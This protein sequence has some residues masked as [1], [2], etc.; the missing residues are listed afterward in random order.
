LA[1]TAIELP[2]FSEE[3]TRNYL[4]AVAAV[5]RD[6]GERSIADT[7]SELSLEQSRKIHR[8]SGGLPILLALLADYISIAGFRRL[9]QV[10]QNEMDPDQA[11]PLL[12]QQLIERLIETSQIRDTLLM[13]GRAP[14]GLNAELLANLLEISQVEAQRRLERIQRLSFVKTRNNLFFLHDEMYAFL[15]RQVYSDP[16]DAPE[17][18]R[19]NTVL[20]NWYD[21]QIKQYRQQLDKRFTPVEQSNRSDST[22]PRLDFNQIARIQQN[23]NQ[24]LV[25]QL[26]Y[27]LRRN[28]LEGSY[29]F[30]RLIFLSIFGANPLLSTHAQAEV[31][32]FFH[33]REHTNQLSNF[34]DDDIELIKGIIQRRRLFE[35]YA[36]QKYEEVVNEAEQLLQQNVRREIDQAMTKVWKILALA[37]SGQGNIETLIAEVEPC[38]KRLAASSKE[39]SDLQSWLARLG[40]ALLY[41]AKG[42]ASNAATRRIE[43]YQ[44]AVKF[45]RRVDIPIGLAWTL[46]NLGFAHISSG[47]LQDGL[48]LIQETIEIRQKIGERAQIGIG[49]ATLSLAHLH[50]GNPK[51][52]RELADRGLRLCRAVNYKLGEGLALRNIAEIQ[53][54]STIREESPEKRLGELQE[55]LSYAREATSIFEEMNNQP[56]LIEALI[57][58]G[59]TLRDMASILRSQSESSESV[60][61]WEELLQESKRVLS[62]AAELAKDRKQLSKAIDAYVTLAAIGIVAK[63]F[64]LLSEWLKRVEAEIPVDYQITTQGKPDRNKFDDHSLFWQLARSHIRIGDYLLASQTEEEIK[65]LAEHYRDLPA[66][67]SSY[68]ATEIKGRSDILNLAIR[69]Y[70]LAFEYDDLYNP[71]HVR[72]QAVQDRLLKQIKEF[73]FE[74]LRTVAEAVSSVEKEFKLRNSFMRHL[75]QRRTLLLNEEDV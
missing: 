8:F 42:Y 64:K 68:A 9:P 16:G 22:T 72:S 62:R 11:R 60:E 7:L 5:A 41:H 59:C 30:V 54:R 44:L 40:L 37:S 19:V 32:T 71:Y 1:L 56:H 31:L 74:N 12:E 38:L 2:P 67:F 13:L 66:R 34:S 29:Q 52:A 39:G 70:T 26:Y 21:K 36:V 51:Q 10:F 24:L 14:K 55:A 4:Q 27:Y 58:E 50:S 17:A 6:A 47:N 65:R 53:R 48:A 57:E 63:D 33:E 3:E 23:I 46:N 75:L 61:N 25:D 73:D 15:H 69:H 43:A 49:Y 20:I 35:L 28:P 18:E 45:W